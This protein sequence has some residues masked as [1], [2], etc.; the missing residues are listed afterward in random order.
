MEYL[1]RVLCTV[2]IAYL[3]KSSEAGLAM[4]TDALPVS[5]SSIPYIADMFGTRAFAGLD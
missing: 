4:V 2:K 5:A 1:A 3:V